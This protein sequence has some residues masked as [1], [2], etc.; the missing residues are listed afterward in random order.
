MS[1]R[2]GKAAAARRSTKKLAGQRTAPSGRASNLR[3]SKANILGNLMKV[4][5]YT[6]GSETLDT[7]RKEISKSMQ[8]NNGLGKT[9]IQTVKQ[10]ASLQA[11]IKNQPDPTLRLEM[12]KK[13]DELANQAKVNLTKPNSKNRLTATL[14]K[15]EGITKVETTTTSQSKEKTKR[16]KRIQERGP[17]KMATKLGLGTGVT[18]FRNVVE[19]V[20]DKQKSKNPE[21]LKDSNNP[22]VVKNLLSSA[23][24]RGKYYYKNNATGDITLEKFS[25]EPKIGNIIKA[26]TRISQM[27]NVRSAKSANNVRAARRKNVEM[28]KKLLADIEK[29]KNPNDADETKVLEDL[30]Q[31]F[32][33]KDSK[34]VTEAELQK[35]TDANK[36]AEAAQQKEIFD[37]GRNREL[38]SRIVKA[39]KKAREENDFYT[40]LRMRDLLKKITEANRQKK[41]VVFDE[42]GEAY[43]ALIKVDPSIESLSQKSAAETRQEAAKTKA[44]ERAEQVAK[45]VR[46]RIAALQAKIAQQGGYTK[47]KHRKINKKNNKI[48]KTRK[49]KK[50]RKNRNNRR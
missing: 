39:L 19:R 25:N 13:F 16:E 10:L 6:K 22:E 8:K 36:A 26:A 38:A 45:S 24:K 21:L 28:K 12:S 43:D 46:G 33:S 23:L 30:K 34:L 3:Q 47:K 2:A 14:R 44:K 37:V 1:K 20:I 7:I 31:S 32:V 50:T 17:G 40:Q 48:L 35:K 15:I 27:N 4:Q 49:V 9:H 18:S 41:E 29:A 11:Q 42:K 5:E